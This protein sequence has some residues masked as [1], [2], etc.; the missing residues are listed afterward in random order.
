MLT[1]NINQESQQIHGRRGGGLCIRQLVMVERQRIST[2]PGNLVLCFSL[3][4]YLVK[5]ADSKAKSTTLNARGVHVVTNGKDQLEG[6]DLVSV[7]FHR[8]IDNSDRI[9]TQSN[10]LKLFELRMLVEASNTTVIF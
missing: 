6:I 1:N 9:L 2:S 10:C 8:I 7:Q 5:T 4:S 3:Y